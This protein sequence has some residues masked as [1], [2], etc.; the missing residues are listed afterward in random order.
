MSPTIEYARRFA[1]QLSVIGKGIASGRRIEL[2][3]HLAQC[4]RSVESLAGV[5]GLSVANTSQHLQQLRHAGLVTSRKSGQHVYY[6]LAADSIVELL[7]VLRRVAVH[8]LPD[9]MQ[10]MRTT[11]GPFD[12][13]PILG[14]AA[15]H[16]GLGRFT[17]IDLRGPEEFDRG[18]VRGAINVPLDQLEGSL[19]FVSKDAPVVVYGRHALCPLAVGSV[20]VLLTQATE[21][22]RLDGGFPDWRSAGYPVEVKAR[23]AAAE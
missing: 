7:E 18:H 22:Y 15:L 19:E 2:L 6:R 11:F 14:L 12:E 23:I 3:D 16:D 10:T 13:A 9:V 1:D 21:L 20:R 4:E 17:V 8:Q 5:A